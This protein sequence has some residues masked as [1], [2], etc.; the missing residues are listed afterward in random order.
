V[1]A[2][3][4]SQADTIEE[5]LT[6]RHASSPTGRMGTP[7]DVANAALFLASDEAAYVNGICLPVDG[8]L[9]M[10]SA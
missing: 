5:L 10:R 9:S 1:R 2:Q 6:V 8:G 4:A 7:W 3:L